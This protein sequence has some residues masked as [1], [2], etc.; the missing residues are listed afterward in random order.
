M[1]GHIFDS[2]VGTLATL[3]GEDVIVMVLDVDYVP[4][5]AHAFLDEVSEFEV[6]QSATTLEVTSTAGVVTVALAVDPEIDISGA[7]RVGG[8]VVALD[9][10]VPA[11]SRLLVWQ[12]DF[13]G[14]APDPYPIVCPDGIARAERDA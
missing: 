13:G 4:D 11:T 6:G 7:V 8:W 2:S 12:A 9:S 14:F 5:T 10:G 1:T 3:D